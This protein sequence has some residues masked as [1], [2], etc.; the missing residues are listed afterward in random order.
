M[1]LSKVLTLDIWSI[2]DV[3]GYIKEI[4][5]QFWSQIMGAVSSLVHGMILEYIFR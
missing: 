1:S 4:K 2:Y 3:V 5:L